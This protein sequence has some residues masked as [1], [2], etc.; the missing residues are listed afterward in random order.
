MSA[1]FP[2]KTWLDRHPHELSG[3]QL[4]RVVLAR[5]LLPHPRLIVAD[6]PVSMLDV[7]VRAGILN[8]LRA[9]R[10]ELGLAAIYISHDLALIRYVCERTLVMYLGRVV[11]EGATAR[12]DLQATASVY[13][14]AGRRGAG[15]ADASRIAA[16][17]P[18]AGVWVMHR[19]TLW[20]VP[21][22][23]AVRMHLNDALLRPQLCAKS[24]PTVWSP[25]TCRMR[26]NL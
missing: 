4:Q 3:G 14:C 8:L 20:A 24:L 23:H 26:H 25:A 1:C 22:A 2:T 16:R 15:A 19:T 17:C 9:A 5:A 7:S 18:S 12:L 13:T 11:E 21:F 10:D 6:E